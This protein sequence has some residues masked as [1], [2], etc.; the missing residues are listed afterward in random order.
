MTQ[1]DE[2][3]RPARRGNLASRLYYGETDFDLIGSRKRWY[4]A[5]AVLVLLCLAAMLLRGFHLGIEFSGGASFRF[6][7]A[8]GVSVEEAREAVEAADVEVVTSQRAGDDF[9][10]RTAEVTEDQSTQVKS[11]LS[12]RLDVPAAS[13]TDQAVSS[14][15]GGQITRKALQGLAVFLVLVIAYISVRFEPK[16]AVAAIAALIHDLILTAGI[17]ALVGFE[18]SPST[19]IGLLTILGFSLY[20]TIVVFDK[21]QE[22]TAGIL[23]GSRTTYARAANLAVNQTFMRSINTSLIALLPV[24]GLL[25]IGAGF[26]GAGTL[27]DLGL[28]LFVG[29]AAGAYSSLFLATPILVDL[30]EREPRHRALAARVQA[31]EAGTPARRT[32]AAARRGAGS[33]AKSAT[34]TAV[35]EREDAG[36]RDDGLQDDR[37]QDDSGVDPAPSPGLEAAPPVRP[38]ATPAAARTT[39][40]RSGSARVGSRA[41]PARRKGGRPSG[42]RK[43]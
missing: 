4:L 25:I 13:I 15:W 24:A 17:Y 31:K 18:V 14:S 5:S 16:M 19:V 38:A 40:S 22:N 7:A 10:V 23:G 35:L 3:R 34:A 33:A 26:L 8:A 30:K 27:K 39:P 1:T 36:L 6:P 21:V 43:R 29:L 2:V 12:E 32:S 11:T 28:V 37:L 9:L 41:Q 42:K 20:D